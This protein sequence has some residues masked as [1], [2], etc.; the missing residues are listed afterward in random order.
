MVWAQRRGRNRRAQVGSCPS[1]TPRDPEQ[2]PKGFRPPGPHLPETKAT[3]SHGW[4]HW[5]SLRAGLCLFLFFSFLS[6][7]SPSTT[8]N[9]VINYWKLAGSAPGAREK[10]SPRFLLFQPGQVCKPSPVLGMIAKPGAQAMP[11]RAGAGAPEFTRGAGR[12]AGEWHRL[13][14]SGTHR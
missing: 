10:S 4:G 1:K 2:D 5:N 8:L 11:L 7:F 3:Y 13:E 9:S 14:R 12:P 6:F